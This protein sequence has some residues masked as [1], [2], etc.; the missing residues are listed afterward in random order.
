MKSSRTAPAPSA[1]SRASFV[2]QAIS[3][4]VGS[5]AAESIALTGGGASLCASGSQLCTGAQP[6]LPA[7]PTIIS[8]NAT[9][10]VSGGSPL[11]CRARD[12][13]SSRARPESPSP[14]AT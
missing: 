6:I 11:A 3:S 10:V 13:Q 9:S 14:T 8:T 2:R 1:G 4:T 5:S 7:S 12:C